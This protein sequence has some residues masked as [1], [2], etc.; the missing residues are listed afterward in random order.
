M[1]P[2]AVEV[3]LT[4]EDR[5]VL[6]ARL[7][8][9]T[10]PQRD[11]LRAR[12]VLLAAEDRST[13]SIARELRTMPRTVSLWRGRYARE[14]LAGLAERRRAG[15]KAKYTE[16]TERRILAVLERRP[17]A[18]FARWTGPLIAAELGDVHVQQVWRVL[19][20]LRID[21]DGRKG[22]CESPDPDFAAKAADIVGLY[23][24]PPEDAIV[25]AVDEKPH[26]Q[27]LE[28]AQG[29][30]RLPNGRALVGHGHTYKRHGTTTLFAALEV[31]TG[32]ITTGHYKRRRRVEFLDFMNRVVATFP[33]RQL[34]VILDNLNTHKPKRDHWLAR[35]P[36][37]HFHF[38]P[39]YASWLNQVEIWFSILSGAALKGASFT[40]PGQLR[41]A[42]DDFV[43]AYN[44]NARPFQWTKS[45]IHQKRL[46]PR[47]S[48]L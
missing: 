35:H 33:G 20:C 27:A 48:H 45:E 30:L 28:R 36:N 5:A 17:P 8:A 39:N 29:Y 42:I 25:L 32:E 2:D 1:I 6:E 40:S 9:P 46:K 31:A 47:I 23:L 15:P 24:D 14:G 12:I 4:P 21:L 38:T 41:E 34:H 37:V 13:R 44:Q 10:T 19:R 18:G 3:R 7:R 16:A 43:A 11:V 26:I 22:W